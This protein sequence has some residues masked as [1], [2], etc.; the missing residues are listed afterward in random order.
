[1]VLKDVKRFTGEFKKLYKPPNS[2]K[3]GG[4]VVKLR[5]KNKSTKNVA[6][7]NSCHLRK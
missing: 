3:R 4:L 6:N 7:A 5:A 1:M 2:S